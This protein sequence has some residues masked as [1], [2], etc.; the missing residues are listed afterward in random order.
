MTFTR[1]NYGKL[2]LML[3]YFGLNHS[4]IGFVMYIIQL[5]V[6][7]TINTDEHLDSEIV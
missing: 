7:D 3:I 4:I 2:S 5:Y 1:I 6:L